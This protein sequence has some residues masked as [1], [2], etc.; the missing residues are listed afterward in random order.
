M[1]IAN[2]IE[3]ENTIFGE[4]Y[5]KIIII[6]KKCNIQETEKLTKLEIANIRM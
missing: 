3:K 4:E 1:I 5:N 2:L 6:D